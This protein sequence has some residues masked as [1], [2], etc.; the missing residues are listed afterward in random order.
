LLPECL[1]DFIAAHVDEMGV[2]YLTNG[3]GLEWPV[4]SKR[5]E[6]LT[7]AGVSSSD[8]HDCRKPTVKIERRV[9]RK[10]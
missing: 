3:A 5:I 6:K 7:V 1:E 9:R 8:F 2:A 4:S 10:S